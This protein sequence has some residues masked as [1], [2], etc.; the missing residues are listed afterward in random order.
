MFLASFHS[1]QDWI[2]PVCPCMPLLAC[3]ASISWIIWFCI[4][5]QLL[6][7]VRY[8]AGPDFESCRSVYSYSILKCISI[9]NIL[10]SNKK[11]RSKAQLVFP[12]GQRN[13]L[14]MPGVVTQDFCGSAREAAVALW[15]KPSQQR[16]LEDWLMGFFLMVLAESTWKW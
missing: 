9:L 11:K 6:S 12:F 3:P 2:F 8:V 10:Q 13:L 15:Q 7:H 14:P 16:T 4:W 5:A 1:N